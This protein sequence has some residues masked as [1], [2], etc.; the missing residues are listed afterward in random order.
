MNRK[1]AAPTV[2]LDATRQRLERLGLVHAA[3][4]SIP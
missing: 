4:N 3:S 2:D 1:T